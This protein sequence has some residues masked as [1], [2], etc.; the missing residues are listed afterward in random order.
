M[1]SQFSEF[2]FTKSAHEVLSDVCSASQFYQIVIEYR[3][4][5]C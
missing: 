5:L 4:V 2:P 3:M 1:L